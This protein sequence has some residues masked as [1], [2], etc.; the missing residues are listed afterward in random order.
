MTTLAMT[1][2]PVAETALIVKPPPILRTTG[3]AADSNTQNVYGVYMRSLL[4]MKIILKITEIGR[5][6]KQNLE[7]KIIKQTEGKCIPQGFIRP[8][9]VRIVSYSSGNVQGGHVEFTAV[10]ECLVCHPV[11][12]MRVECTA[13]TITKAGIHAEVITDDGV[14]PLTLFIA[15]DHNYKAREFDKVKENSKIQVKILGIRYELND[16]YICAIGMLVN[17]ETERQRAMKQPNPR[18]KILEDEPEVA[19]N[20][21]ELNESDEEAQ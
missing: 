21:T 3:K 16:P 18:V 17:P 20:A 7:R 14:V 5:Q 2:P 10:Y 8:N 13:K 6:V 11:E 9:S 19:V 15:R 1:I 12:N 4:T